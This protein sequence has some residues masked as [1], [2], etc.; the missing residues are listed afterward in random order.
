[1]SVEKNEKLWLDAIPDG[2][3]CSNDVRTTISNLFQYFCLRHRDS[4]GFVRTYGGY[5]K[6]SNTSLAI[7]D[8][9][10][11]LNELLPKK[12]F[13]K[14]DASA[15]DTDYHTD[16][17][18]YQSAL[19]SLY[20]MINSRNNYVAMDAHCFTE[21][22]VE[23]VE[24]FF[25]SLCAKPVRT[26]GV[27]KVLTQTQQGLSF[28]NF[29]EPPFETFNKDNYTD[30]VYDD[31]KYIS[32]DLKKEDPNGRL[33]IINGPPGTGKT[34]FIKSLICDTS[35]KSFILIPLKFSAA[36]DNPDFARLLMREREKPLIIV[37]EDADTALVRRGPDNMSA[38]SS[39]L[40]YTDGLFGSLLDLRIIATTN[41]ESLDIE[42]ALL[43]DGRLSRHSF[44]GPLPADK[45][46]KLY[47][48][49]TN[50]SDKPFSKE[51][52]IAEIYG[53]RKNVQTN[54]KLQ[55]KKIKIVGFG[56]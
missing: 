25:D 41:A 13:L 42:P 45:A 50:T 48:K 3:T 43:R 53:L 33:F 27:V 31:Y 10:E 8:V 38:I 51:T 37:L 17:K 22:D 18:L 54:S 20:V 34:H 40:N 24:D 4:V 28:E 39:L 5:L 52:T 7:V 35:G 19:G 15:S 21:K 46:N 23:I 44:I 9:V 29:I 6:P 56:S 32:E 2:F 49:L 55:N 16:I 36:L 11:K 26:K 14:F 12:F 1:M 47:Q 30:N